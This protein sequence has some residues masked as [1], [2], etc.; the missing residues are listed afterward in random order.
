MTPEKNPHDSGDFGEN[1]CRVRGILAVWEFWAPNSKQGAG[2]GPRTGLSDNRRPKILNPVAM[3][4]IE[5]AESSVIEALPAVVA[6]HRSA[7]I[8]TWKLIHQIEDE[9]MQEVAKSGKHSPQL[10]RMIKASPAMGY[11]RDD[12]PADFTGSD[13]MPPTFSAIVDAWNMVN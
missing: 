6:K 10:L 3:N 11:P 13:V 5:A 2:R 9:V 4:P 8:L 7:G 1:L 12:T